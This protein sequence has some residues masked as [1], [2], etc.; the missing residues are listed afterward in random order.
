MITLTPK[1]AQ[2]IQQLTSRQGKPE[3]FLRV[4]VV[5]GG[6]SGLSYEFEISNQPASG[7]K[8]FEFHGAKLVTDASALSFWDGS[9]VDYAET[10]MKSGFTVK[11]PHAQ[12]S[13]G[14]GVSFSV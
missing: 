11:N 13:C 4:R 12:G 1:A 9:E 2:K 10:L 8:V 3:G 5:A 6:C 14:C 7:D